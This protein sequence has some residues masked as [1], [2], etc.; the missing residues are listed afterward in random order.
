MNFSRAF[1]V[2]IIDDRKTLH[3]LPV[4]D[5]STIFLSISVCLSVWGSN[6][7]SG[8]NFNVC[9]F[10]AGRYVEPF[11][12]RKIKNIII[13]VLCANRAMYLL[14]RQLY[15]SISLGLCKGLYRPESRHAHAVALQIKT[16]GIADLFIVILQRV[17]LRLRFSAGYIVAAGFGGNRNILLGARGGFCLRFPLISLTMIAEILSV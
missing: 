7:L 12:C 17:D 9:Y 1:F 6:A 13:D 4:F 16:G 11:T 5:L 3:M 8:K 10:A 2:E 15:Y 14:I